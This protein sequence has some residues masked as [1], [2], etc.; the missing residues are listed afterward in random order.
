MSESRCTG[1]CCEAFPV[2]SDDVFMTSHADLSKVNH[3]DQAML[4]EMLVETGRTFY[5][6]DTRPDAAM[7]FTC[8]FFDGRNCTIY[9]RRP[10]MCRRYG[11]KRPCT[12]QGCT[13]KPETP[14]EPN[15]S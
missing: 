7:L 11:V 8:K 6:G 12:L 15:K 3:P 9:D 13:F 5:D 4:R 2:S 10:D 14:I 1:Q